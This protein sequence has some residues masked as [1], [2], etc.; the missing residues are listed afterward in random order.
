MDYAAAWMLIA[1]TAFGTT[2]RSHQGPAGDADEHRAGARVENDSQAPRLAFG[3]LNRCAQAARRAA[4]ERRTGFVIVRSRGSRPARSSGYTSVRWR[5]PASPSASCDRPAASRTARRSEANVV[6]GF[7]DIGPRLLTL[8]ARVETGLSASLATASCSRTA[9]PWEVRA[10][11][12]LRV[13][14]KLAELIFAF[15]N[16]DSGSPQ[17]CARVLAPRWVIASR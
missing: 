17:W 16:T 11:Q 10:H 14:A 3:P 2:A 9:V 15:A 13:L 4:I 1:L 7:Y 8:D 12:L 6:T 5:P